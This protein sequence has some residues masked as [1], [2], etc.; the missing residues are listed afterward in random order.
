MNPI[1]GIRDQPHRGATKRRKRGLVR[2]IIFGGART[3]SSQR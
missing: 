1:D 2:F 3:Q